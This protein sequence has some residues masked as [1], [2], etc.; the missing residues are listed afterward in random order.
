VNSKEYQLKV[1]LEDSLVSNSLV[2]Q[3]QAL[4]AGRLPRVNGTYNDLYLVDTLGNYYAAPSLFMNGT[5]FDIDG[6]QIE[7]TPVNL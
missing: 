5:T 4:E 3:A 7:F 2:G 6:Q 1:E